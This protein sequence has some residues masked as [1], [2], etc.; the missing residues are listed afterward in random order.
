MKKQLLGQVAGMSKEELIH[1][2]AELGYTEQRLK[3]AGFA[4][5]AKFLYFA[6]TQPIDRWEQALE[7]QAELSARRAPWED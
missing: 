6:A 4:R 5:A 1:L 2:R 3:K 7:R